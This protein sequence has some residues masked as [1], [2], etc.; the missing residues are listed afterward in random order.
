MLTSRK[1][2]SIIEYSIIAALVM[3]AIIFGGPTLLNSIRAYFKTTSDNMHDSFHER[4]VQAPDS[5]P[6][7]CTCNAPDNDPASWPAST[8]GISPCTVTQR[9]HYRS[10]TPLKC[11]PEVACVSDDACC[12]APTLVQCGTVVDWNGTPYDQ[13]LSRAA[14]NSAKFGANFKGTCMISK[15]GLTVDSSDCAIGERLYTVTC[16]G[17]NNTTKKYYGC[18]TLTGAEQNACLPSCIWEG[19]NGA[20]NNSAAPCTTQADETNQSLLDEE[21]AYRLYG[22]IQPN[23]TFLKDNPDRGLKGES[24]G[25]DGSHYLAWDIPST[26]L[27][28]KTGC[29]RIPTR[30]CEYYKKCSQKILIITDLSQEDPLTISYFGPESSNSYVKNENPATVTAQYLAGFDM[31]IFNT[32]G[33]NLLAPYMATLPGIISDWV[34]GG[35]TFVMLGGYGNDYGGTADAY[36]AYSNKILAP[37]NITMSQNTAGVRTVSWLNPPSWPFLNQSECYFYINGN[38]HITC[39]NHDCTAFANAD[40]SDP[41]VNKT[42]GVVKN[43]GKGKVLVWGDEFVMRNWMTASAYKDVSYQNKKFWSN[44][45][46]WSINSPECYICGKTFFRSS[47]GNCPQQATRLMAASP[48]F[49]GPWDSTGIEISGLYGYTSDGWA[50]VQNLN[51]VNYCMF[52][53]YIYGA[54]YGNETMAENPPYNSGTPPYTWGAPSRNASQSYGLSP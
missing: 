19:P 5:N 40:N 24:W 20:A 3:S 4:M 22:V 29:S 7:T 35:G 18:K 15:D 37:F 36:D 45:F 12:T 54:E 53:D 48:D 17:P 28:S 2:Q 33:S 10:C 38:S 27:S 34:N 25:T 11:K 6:I 44:V 51:G 16:G 26:V 39:P 30:R 8:C 52:M 46:A 14:F 23:G 41:S 21:V 1:G 32:A 9:Y 50:F 42:L 43:V 31:V 49:Y 13:C 47:I